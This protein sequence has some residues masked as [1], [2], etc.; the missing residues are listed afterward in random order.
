MDRSETAKII[1]VIT[2]TYAKHFTGFTPVQMENLISAWCM[3]LE[4]YTYEQATAGL[5]VYLSCD[6]K[7]FPPS[8]GQVIDCIH[9]MNPEHEMTGLEA[10]EVV[11]KAVRNGIYDYREEFAKLPPL[12][13]KVIGNP[14]T[15]REWGIMDKDVLNSVEKSH[16][17]REYEMTVKREK[18]DAK[19]PKKVK[20]LMMAGG[21][22]EQHN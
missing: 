22:I 2:A 18:E 10:W 21:L 8:P 6:T 14:V 17:I 12:L 4:D 11:R 3:V 1:A 9:K 13:Q 5:K 19:I 16:F 15:I 7:G 20:A